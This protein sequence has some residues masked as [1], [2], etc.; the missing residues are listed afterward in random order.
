MQKKKAIDTP[1]AEFGVSWKYFTASKKHDCES[2]VEFTST[3]IDEIVENLAIWLYK[4]ML[5]N[6]SYFG[7]C[8]SKLATG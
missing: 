3:I 8:V 2:R 1:S 4:L 7:V 5:I 6:Y